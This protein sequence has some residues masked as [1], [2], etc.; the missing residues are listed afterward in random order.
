[1]TQPQPPVKKTIEY[2]KAVAH[3]V[4]WPLLVLSGPPTAFV[5]FLAIAS[6]ES[7]A[8]QFEDVPP[9]EN[10]FVL[11][12]IAQL[13]GLI[14]VGAASGFSRTLAAAGLV[15]F[16]MVALVVGFAVLGSMGP[17]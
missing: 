5:I 7:L 4:A 13:V 11:F 10:L 17:R 2:A 3:F 8:Q 9:F 16:I 15:S 6:G 12:V 1:M 14:L